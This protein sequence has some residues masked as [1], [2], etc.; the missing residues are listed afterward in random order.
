MAE[1]NALVEK[2]VFN[3]KEYLSSA[4]RREVEQSGGEKG[5]KSRNS[6]E[7]KT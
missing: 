3:G 7:V 2:E 1:E 4:K 5:K 6:L